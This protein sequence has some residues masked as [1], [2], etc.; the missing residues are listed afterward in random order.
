MMVKKKKKFYDIFIVRTNLW[1][2]HQYKLEAGIG[3]II[4]ERL[5]PQRINVIDLEK[6]ELSLLNE[7][8]SSDKLN[9]EQKVQLSNYIHKFYEQQEKAG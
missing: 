3:E 2:Q 4:V 7:L 5:I 9:T 6:E 8:L 1:K